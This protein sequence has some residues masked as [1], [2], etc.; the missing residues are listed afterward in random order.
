MKLGSY[1]LDTAPTFASGAAGPVSGT[2]DAAIIG[3]G[4]TGLSAALALARQGANV[5]VLEA[6][7]VAAAA[8]GRNGGHC[9]N[10][11]AKG[12]GQ[13]VEKLGLERACTLYQAFDA[14]V[15]TVER[16]AAEEAI[17]CDFRRSGK[18]QLASKPAHFGALARNHE[19]LSRGTD[20]DTALIPA[21]GLDREIRSTRFHGGLLYRRSAM[22]HVGRFGIGLA[23]AA[24]RK[25]A[26]IFE[27]AAVTGLRR[28]SGPRYEVTSARGSLR[29][30]AVLVATGAYT[31]GPLPFFR[32]RIAPVGS[33]IV[34]TEPLAP[35]RVDA[36]MPTRRTAVTTKNIGNYFRISPDDRLIFGG[37]ARFA[38]SNPASDAKS[39]RILAHALQRIFPQLGEVGLDYC[40]GGL[41][42][43]TADRLPRA[44]QQDGLFYAMGYS[45]HGVQMSV[46]MGEIMADIMAGKADANPW[47]DLPWPAMPGH[48]GTP[49]F[50]PLV[51][52][53][54]RILDCLR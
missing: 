48:F 24:A 15:D 33:F 26:R 30:E 6:G 53:Y 5:V 35:E 12:F 52:A 46:H 51:G 34:T 38:L 47:N 39:G 32:R 27:Q 29:A 50:L 16:L 9:N 23:E 10:G 14:A 42:D 43:V 19:L 21:A 49:W 13:T 40:W 8:S 44:G 2:C 37:R 20:T 7:G 1:W 17:D 45:G 54:Y 25:G 4:F 18:I 28:L 11:L 22:L 3:G 41:I 36:I 31:S